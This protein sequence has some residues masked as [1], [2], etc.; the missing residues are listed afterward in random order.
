MDS[1][2]NFLAE[3]S[4]KNFKKAGYELYMKSAFEVTPWCSSKYSDNNNNCLSRIVNF[5][6]QALNSEHCLPGYIVVLLDDNLIE[7][8]NY[9]KF[10]V[11][12]LFGSWPEYLAQVIV[13]SVEKRCQDL[14]LKARLLEKTQVYFVKPVNHDNFDYVNQQVRETFSQCL[15]VT[16]NYMKQCRF[17]NCM[18]IGINM[19][20]I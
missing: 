17:L 16:S 1:G 18:I 5:I 12:S 11:A 6:M 10:G 4:R 13:E 2:D 9:K 14:P 7:Y 19:M 20:I 3:M 15:D 8:L